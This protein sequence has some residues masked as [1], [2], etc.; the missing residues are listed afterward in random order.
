MIGVARPKPTGQ[1]GVQRADRR[2]G[3]G[4]GRLSR[5]RH[6]PI[7]EAT[8][9]VVN[10][11]PSLLGAVILPYILPL[12]LALGLWRAAHGASERTSPAVPTGIAR[13]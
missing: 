10:P 8:S 13:D 3:E 1:P 4:A 6:P 9:V 12:L 2:V 5:R 11:N 7:T